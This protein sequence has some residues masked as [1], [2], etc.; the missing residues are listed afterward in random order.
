MDV[1]GNGDHETANL[2]IQSKANTAAKDEA[3][4]RVRAKDEARGA[5]L[6][7]VAG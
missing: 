5:R 6:C 1:A 4:V 2:L 3:R 7:F